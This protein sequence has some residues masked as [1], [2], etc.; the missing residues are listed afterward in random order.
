MV[1]RKS[2]ND[3]AFE[4]KLGLIG[5]VV[6]GLLL[7]FPFLIIGIV[8]YFNLKSRFAGSSSSQR[9]FEVWVLKKPLIYGMSIAF[10]LWLCSFS[11]LINLPARGGDFHSMSD[12]EI[13]LAVMVFI[14]LF[15]CLCWVEYHVARWVA[16]TYFGVVVDRG[17]G[18]IYLPKDMLNYGVSDYFKLKFITEL[19]VMESINISDITRITRQKTRAAQVYHLYV[20][21]KFGSRGIWFNHKQKRD[22]CMAAIED[23]LGRR[24]T[25]IE[26]E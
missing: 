1:E 18:K 2:K 12:N 23:A 22:E 21:G 9:I 25:M 24:K 6:I 19:G 17:S 16:A 4:Q 5:M 7:F 11:F 14:L 10:V 15:S 13:R 8:H 3:N 26:F 20:E